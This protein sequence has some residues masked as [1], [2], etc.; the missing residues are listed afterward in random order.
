MRKK[1]RGGIKEAEGKIH[2]ENTEERGGLGENSLLVNLWMFSIQIS[3]RQLSK[4]VWGLGERLCYSTQM[5]L[6]L[7]G[8]SN[9]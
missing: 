1:K 4:C 6:K 3:S 8:K 7:R 9:N 2:L 5:A